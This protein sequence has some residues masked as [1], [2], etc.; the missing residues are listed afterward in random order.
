MYGGISAE[1]RGSFATDHAD[2]I[3][4]LASISTTDSMLA[5]D[6]NLAAPRDAGPLCGN[7][8]I[9]GPWRGLAKI[10]QQSIDFTGFEAYWLEIDIQLE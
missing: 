1:H 8:E 5:E 10:A 2:V 9:V 4:S 3:I 6:P 7:N